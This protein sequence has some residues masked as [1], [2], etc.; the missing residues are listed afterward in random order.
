MCMTM[1][2]DISKDSCIGGWQA[3]LRS[4]RAKIGRLTKTAEEF[5]SLA[6]EGW[7]P[8]VSAYACA[9]HHLEHSLREASGPLLLLDLP[10]A[11][12]MLHRVPRRLKILSRCGNTLWQSPEYARC[13]LWIASAWAACSSHLELTGL[14]GHLCHLQL[15]VHELE[16]SLRIV[17]A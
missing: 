1:P 3:V 4:F 15:H 7:S 12:P 13:R 2:H 8:R 16:A 10:G 14:S 11:P 6:S 5:R 9:A 17:T